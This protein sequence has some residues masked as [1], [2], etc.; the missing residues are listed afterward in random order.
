MEWKLYFVQGME[1]LFLGIGTYFDIRDRKLPEW[2]LLVFGGLGVACN[3]F[4]NYQKAAEAVAGLCV[5]GMFLLIGW[6]TGEAIGYG[7]GI[8]LMIL[9]VL[10]GLQ[11]ILPILFIAFFCSGIYGLWKMIGCGRSKNDTMPFYPFLF[12]ALMGVIVL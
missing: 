7:D 4:L 6:I 5:G 3:L 12:L 9:G 1:L 8:G 10:G 11:G 2:F